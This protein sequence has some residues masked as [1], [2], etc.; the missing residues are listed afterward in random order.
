MPLAAFTPIRPAYST[1]F[2]KVEFAQ[3]RVPRLAG[4]GLTRRA[5][6]R[7]GDVPRDWG[8][9]LAQAAR[10][11]GLYRHAAALW[12]A[13]ASLGSTDAARQL[14]T[15][16]RRVNPGD[17]MRVGHWAVGHVSLDDPEAVASLL[18]EL[19]EAGAS[20]AVTARP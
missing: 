1:L 7:P 20:N 8:G 13:A 6:G 15:H 5:G 11:R 18:L 3:M 2:A 19:R 16:L 4:A 9:R 17:T 12:T 10:D 14:I